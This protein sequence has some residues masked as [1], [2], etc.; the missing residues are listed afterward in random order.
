MLENWRADRYRQPYEDYLPEV[1][2]DIQ[3][4]IRPLLET[5]SLAEQRR[6]G[7][8]AFINAVLRFLE[9]DLRM[10]ILPWELE[11]KPR[12]IR[13]EEATERDAAR[14]YAIQSAHERRAQ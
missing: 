6:A 10:I 1:H 14:R 8:F 11:A 4:V 3:S 9:N 13:E 7:S 12:P 2:R 5:A